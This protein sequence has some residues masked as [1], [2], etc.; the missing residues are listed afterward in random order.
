[1]PQYITTKNSLRAEFQYIWFLGNPRYF[2]YF[3]TVIWE[4]VRRFHHM[5]KGVHDTKRFLKT[6]KS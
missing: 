3:K 1:M 6:Y 5:V 2:I 4:E